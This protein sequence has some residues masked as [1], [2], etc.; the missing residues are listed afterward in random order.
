MGSLLG[1]GQDPGFTSTK[2]I[3]VCWCCGGSDSVVI[4]SWVQGPDERTKHL[5]QEPSAGSSAH[6]EDGAFLQAL[7]SS[8]LKKFGKWR[9]VSITTYQWV[10]CGCVRF[11]CSRWCAI[12]EYIFLFLVHFPMWLLVIFLH[13]HQSSQSSLLL[14]LVLHCEHVSLLCCIAYVLVMS[15]IGEVFLV[16]RVF[17]H[18]RSCPRKCAARREQSGRLCQRLQKNSSSDISSACCTR[19]A[20][21]SKAPWMWQFQKW[22]HLTSVL[23]RLR[24]LECIFGPLKQ[25]QCQKWIVWRWPGTGE[26][27]TKL[28]PCPRSPPG[29][30]ERCCLGKPLVGRHSTKRKS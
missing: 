1:D 6:A 17:S 21:H 8:P 11:L 23:A 27:K 13:I 14:T 24:L 29:V 3:A 4:V 2:S 5:W 7:T 19:S 10:G 22:F 26:G 15:R 12:S 16:Q 9:S 28:E 18:M 20:R 30:C 25:V